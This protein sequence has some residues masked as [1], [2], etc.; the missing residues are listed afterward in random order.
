MT[1]KGNV[2]S[3]DVIAK[4]EESLR[5]GDN[6]VR[7]YYGSI[8]QT[9]RDYPY[10]IETIVNVPPDVLEDGHLLGRPEISVEKS[11]E[12]VPAEAPAAT[13]DKSTSPAAAP[14][15]PEPATDEEEP[16]QGDTA[17]ASSPQPST[18]N[19]QSAS[20]A[21]QEADPAPSESPTP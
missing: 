16:V 18:E 2:T 10:Q 14:A 13:P 21:M 5:Y 1:L 19:E 4:L 9:R 11:A 7:G 3:S 6:L 20:D 8:D 12:K 17:D 15:A